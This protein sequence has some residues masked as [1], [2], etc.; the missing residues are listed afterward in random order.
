ETGQLRRKIQDLQLQL[1]EATSTNSQLNLVVA[2][3]EK[4]VKGN[5]R[6][7]GLLQ[8]EQETLMERFKGVTAQLEQQVQSLHQFLNILEVFLSRTRTALF[9]S[10][11]VLGKLVP[12]STLC[13]E[14]FALLGALEC[15]RVHLEVFSSVAHQ[16]RPTR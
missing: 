1:K 4:S 3:L 8:S 5:S 6:A 7:I 12:S 10:Y 9:R 11:K 13:S 2:G 14:Y 15:Y 16:Q